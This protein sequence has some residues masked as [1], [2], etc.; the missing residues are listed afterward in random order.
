MSLS[1]S[2]SPSVHVAPSPNTELAELLLLNSP[3]PL[4]SL[5]PSPLVVTAPPSVA[6]SQPPHSESALPTDPGPY[7]SMSVDDEEGID[8]DDLRAVVAP[9]HLEMPYTSEEEGWLTQQLER[10]R[11]AYD[12]VSLGEELVN[13]FM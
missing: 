12:Q 3:L 4:P 11:G 8:D 10:F 1:V 6:P 7:R 5:A 9:K 13:E 2:V